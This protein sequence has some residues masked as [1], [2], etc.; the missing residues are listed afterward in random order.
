METLASDIPVILF[1]AFDRHNFGDLLF[2][3]VAATMLGE[4]KLVFAGLASRD[5]RACG[6]HQVQAIAQIAK[7]WGERPVDIMHAGGELLTCTAWEAAVMLLE[8]AQARQVIARFDAHSEGTMQWAREELGLAGHAPYTVPRSLFPC[9]RHIIYNGVGGVDFDAC[10][11]AMQAEVL[12]NLNAADAVGVRDR[13]TQVLLHAGGVDTRLLPDPAVMTAELFGTEIRRRA[14]EGEVAQL[15]SAFPHGYVAVQFNTSFDDDEILGELATQF[16]DLAREQGVVLFR[17]GTAPWHDELKCYRRLAACMRSPHVRIFT[18]VHLWEI[19][20][21]IASSRAYCGSSLHGRIV[22]M[23]FG[24]PRINLMHPVQSGRLTKQDAFAAAW[25]EQGMATT[26]DVWETA[27]GIRQ[28]MA[29][30]RMRLEEKA[31]E[32]A[33]AYRAGFDVLCRKL[34]A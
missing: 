23:A 7:E 11:P 32:L 4:R 29:V 3:H 1:G 18:S 26:V 33:A 27:R 20:A 10:E 8:P 15:L 12:S 31:G 25:E 14:Q 6:G 24:M 5:L 34:R 21:L 17:A 13:R 19:C 30:D 22:A 9:A 16:D 28:A 2:P